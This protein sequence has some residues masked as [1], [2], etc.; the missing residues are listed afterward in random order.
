MEKQ[1]KESRSSERPRRSPLAQRNRL[2]IRDRDPN[3]HYRL[4]NVNLENDPDRV[5]ALE[6]QG[7]EIVPSKKAGPTGDSKVDNPSPVGSAGLISV[8]Q[9]TKAVWMRIRKDWF[10]EDQ[11]VKQE[12]INATEQRSKKQGADYGSV[13]ISSTRG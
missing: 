3:Y 2:S 8:G 12:E 4:V 7:Y 6:E 9:G 11:A 1:L 13:E 10:T 5:E